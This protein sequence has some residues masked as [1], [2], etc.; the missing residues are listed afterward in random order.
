M[1]RGAGLIIL[2]VGLFAPVGYWLITHDDKAGVIGPEQEQLVAPSA[3]RPEPAERTTYLIAAVCLPTALFGMTWLTRRWDEGAARWRVPRLLAEGVLAVGLVAVAWWAAAGDEFYHLRHHLFA[4]Y[5]LLGVCLSLLAFLSLFWPKRAAIWVRGFGWLTAAAVV[6]LVVYGS[7]IDDRHPYAAAYHFNAFYA[8]VVSAH[9]GRVLTVDTLNQYGL[10]AQLLQPLFSLIGLNVTT[11]TAVL[12]VLSGVSYLAVWYGLVRVV[13]NPWVAVFG[14]LA[15]VFFSWLLPLDHSAMDRYYQYRPLRILFPMLAFAGA[16]WYFRRPSRWLYLVS[17]SGLAVGVLWNVDAG[18]PAMVAWLGGRALTAVARSGRWAAVR[19][20]AAD[21]L[22]AAGVLVAAFAVYSGVVYSAS[23]VAPDFGQMLLFQKVFYGTGFAMLP[24]PF[25]G[26]WV[27]VG[28]VYLSGLVFGLRSALAGNATPQAHAAFVLSLLGIALFTYYQGRSHPVVLLAAAWPAVPL[29]A[30]LLDQIASSRR[31][32]RPLH[33]TAAALLVWVLGGAAAGVVPCAAECRAI[34]RYQREEMRKDFPAGRAAEFISRYAGPGEEVLILSMR[35]ALLHQ[36][37]GTRSLSAVSYNELLRKAD[38][39]EILRRFEQGRGPLVFRDRRSPEVDHTLLM[40]GQER[41]AFVA[42]CEEGELWEYRP[43]S[44]TRGLAVGEPG[45]TFVRFR[46]AEVASGLRRLIPPPST[47]WVTLELVVRPHPDQQPYSVLVSNL[48]AMDADLRGFALVQATPGTLTL[49]T[50]DG[51]SPRAALTFPI[52]AGR[53]NHL[54]VT[55]DPSQVRAYVNGRQAAAGPPV[56]LPAPPPDAKVVIGDAP[57]GGRAFRGQIRRWRVL[58]RAFSPEEVAA[59]ARL[60]EPGEQDPT[61]PPT[62]EEWER[63]TA[64]PRYS[65]TILWGPGFPFD[66]P[67]HVPGCAS[68]RWTDSAGELRLLSESPVPRKVRLR[69][70]THTASGPG[71]LQVSGPGFYETVPVTVSP[72]QFEQ[73]FE[74]SPGQNLLRFRCDAPPLVHP[75]RTVVFAVHGLTVL[76]ATGEPMLRWASGFSVE[77]TTP[78]DAPSR[79]RWS[80]AEGTLSVLNPTPN[81]RRVKMTF[82]AAPFAPAPCTL[83]VDG[84]GVNDT[85]KL[86][87]SGVGYDRVFDLPPGVSD[88]RFKCDGEKLVHPARTIAFRLER[89]ALELEPKKPTEKPR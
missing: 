31:L 40:L 58:P 3:C 61:P 17:L 9:Q 38:L 47:P 83:W 14:L 87:P 13:R 16:V 25:P 24:M 11:F 60:V 27:L 84:P 62:A 69:F 50:A 7:V 77:E 19:A 74:L 54:V 57:T 78:G 42:G 68:F 28:L 73:E 1:L 72:G 41:F 70:V 23:G 71:K 2:A 67:S 82:T 4:T 35:D 89:F 34:N 10:Y 52:D 20:I 5:P 29:S 86:T 21:G 56:T 88:I 64:D 80:D 36:L 30:V 48:T 76:P 79:F 46:D 65:P 18:L 85:V 22:V 55:L 66:E 37:T 43:G 49:V 45:T 8:A 75:T 32:V 81:P 39:A 12:G 53:W 6:A 59:E 26:A 15:L 63:R 44:P 33:L 51:G